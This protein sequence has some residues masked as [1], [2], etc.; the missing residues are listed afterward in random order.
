MKSYKIPEAT[1][2]R[3]SV[4]SRYLSK[5]E[6]QGLE[7]ISSGEIAEGSGVSPAHVRKDLAYFGE[8]GTRGV[9]YNVKELHRHIL[10]ILG[11][12]LKWKVVIVGVGHLGT[13][14]A[15]Y[16][17]FRDRKFEIVSLFDV[18]E[19][20]FGKVYEGIEVKPFNDLEKII[21]EENVDIGIITTPTSSA[22]SVADIF[23]NSGI[24]A[25]LNFAP[26]V[27]NV[28]YNIELRNV[29]LA[30]NLEVLTFNIASK[31]KK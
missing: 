17:G 2:A 20:K 10:K 28:P 22:Q 27:L 19:S 21:K 25:I 26:C 29:D 1:I 24:K 23:V 31:Q 30:V 13:A 4:Y 9:G 5:V 11:L 7:L 14:L 16:R 15:M 18:D 8:F 6:Q 3:L 12:D